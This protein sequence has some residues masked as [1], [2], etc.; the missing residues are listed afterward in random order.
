GAALFVLYQA[1]GHIQDL[2]RGIQYWESA[3]SITREDEVERAERVGNLGGT[4]LKRWARLKVPKDL[5]KAIELGRS[6]V[7]NTHKDPSHEPKILDS[8]ACMLRARCVDAR[9]HSNKAD[10]EEAIRFWKL[11]MRLAPPGRPEM[12]QFYS[13]LGTGLET[14]YEHTK[15]VEDLREA[16]LYWNQSVGLT[17]GKSPPKVD[18]ATNLGH[19]YIKLFRRTMDRFYQERALDLFIQC[20][21]NFNGTPLERLL[22]GLKAA[23]VAQENK[24]WNDCA[25]YLAECID[26]LPEVATPSNSQNDLEHVLSQLAGLGPRAATV[27]PRANRSATESLQALD[28]C[29]AVIGSLM[30]DSKSDYSLLKEHHPGL[31]AEYKSLRESISKGTLSS[32]LPG[33]DAD[34]DS[35]ITNLAVTSEKRL[36]DMHRISQVLSEIREKPEFE[37]FQLAPSEADLLALAQDGPIVCFNVTDLA[38]HAF[39][40]NCERIWAIEL[41]RLVEKEVE[42]HVATKVPGNETRRDIKLASKLKSKTSDDT[43]TTT[44]E[45]QLAWL[46]DVAVCPVLRE[47]GLCKQD[48]GHAAVPHVWWVGGGPMALLPLHAAGNHSSGSTDNTMSYAVSSYATS[49]KMLQH[50]RMKSWRPLTAD[51]SKI[52]VVAMHKTPGMDHLELKDEISAIRALES[53]SVAVQILEHPRVATV[54]K[55]ITECSA[56]HFACH[57]SSN[58]QEPSMSAFHLGKATIDT[59]SV[60]DLQPLNHQL[61]QVAYLS[62]CSTAEIGARSLIDESIHLASTFQMVGFRHVI[63][64]LWPADDEA[65]VK[66]AAAFYKRLTDGKD[67]DH[68][69]LNALHYA[70]LGWKGQLDCRPGLSLERKIRFWAPF[71]HLGP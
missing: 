51:K 62:A 54:L 50:S 32:T 7:D 1:Q 28:K 10:L 41:P 37:R 25:K 18:R 59:L 13:N 45:T 60:K 48:K 52:L 14:L 42:K 19:G 56:V 5:E 29:R 67:G 66:I 17:D 20:L 70:V 39:L 23:D 3:I 63:G 26:L 34:V 61:S 6:A 71:I 65:A 12:G 36:R 30:I 46:W 27:Y 11:A 43:R 31:A 15:D 4:Y 2:E 58:N 49:L 9:E 35:S 24:E 64:T 44:L 21:H 69:V 38:S 40:V 8:L 22:A 47:L 57:A 68:S 55:S 16:I 33:V 53:P